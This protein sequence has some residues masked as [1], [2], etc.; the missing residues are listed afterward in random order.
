MQV[1]SISLTANEPRRLPAGNYFRLLD[2]V[3]AISVKYFNAQNQNV[4]LDAE[5]VLS[6]YGADI[7][8]DFGRVTPEIT[9]PTTQTIQWG[10]SFEG[11]RGEYDRSN[12]NVDV[13]TLPALNV[14]ERYQLNHI[15]ALQ[16]GRYITFNTADLGA[17]GVYSYID[18]ENYSDLDFLLLKVG[19]LGVGTAFE[20]MAQNSAFNG[21]LTA[22][23]EKAQSPTA[24]IYS[25]AD[26]GYTNGQ[27]ATAP[28]SN[29]RQSFIVP[30]NNFYNVFDVN[31]LFLHSDTTRDTDAGLR[32]TNRTVNTVLNM[33]FYGVLL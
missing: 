2:S 4:D 24:A 10:R 5:N 25:G 21:A 14:P 22:V 33:F 8:P 26:M 16:D 3:G 20:V 19:I 27:R 30:A 13:L 15:D 32:F 12:G 28:N 9:S 6:G 11:G 7:P 29:I 18:I 17:A 31:N 23:T 1:R